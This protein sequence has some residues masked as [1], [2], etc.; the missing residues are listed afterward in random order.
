M[1]GAGGTSWAKVENERKPEN[2]KS[3]IF[4]DWGIPTLTC[5][6]QIAGLKSDQ[7]FELIAS[8]GIRSSQDIAKSICLG[9]DFAAAA[10]P[11][12]KA[13]VNDGYEGLESL[14]QNWRHQLR[15]ILTLLGCEQLQDL[16]A[17]HLYLK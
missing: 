17:D 7:N 3:E 16:N 1:A 8:G 14:Y 4:N 2:E 11:V 15:I 10:Q 12:I 9:A 5:V 6:R 13:I